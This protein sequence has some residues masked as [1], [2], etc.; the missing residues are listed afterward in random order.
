MACSFID[1]E[2]DDIIILSDLDEIID[3]R[4][5]D[6][7]IELVRKHDI[8]TVLLRQTEMYFNLFVELSKTPNHFLKGYRVYVMSGNYFNNMKMSSN[9]LRLSGTFG[10]LVDKVY[11]YDKYVGFHHSW[12]GDRNYISNKLKSYAHDENDNDP[13]IYNNGEVNN[14]YVRDCI[15]QR[16]SIAGSSHR[17]YIDRNI[18][19]LRS[20]ES[21]KDTEYN[22]YFL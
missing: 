13:N 3:S 12:L 20:V 15:E 2:D 16:K 8:I 10:K 6:E 18:E 21:L 17:L 11:C 4:Y 19:L 9:E 14:N 5:A 22:K 1:A 7:I